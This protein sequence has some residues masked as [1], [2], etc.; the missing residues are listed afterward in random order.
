MPLKFFALLVVL[1]PFTAVH[2]SYLFSAWQG[3]VDWCIPYWHGCT[4]ISAAGRQ[5]VAFFVFKGLMIPAAVLMAGYWWLN[6]RWLHWLGD[7]A[8]GQQRLIVVVG[9][10]ASLGLILYSSVLGAVGDIYRIERRTGVMLYFGLTLLAQLLM[11]RRVM[12]LSKILPALNRP[13][14]CQLAICLAM[15]LLGVGHLLAELLIPATALNPER[16]LDD[17]V[18]WNF[19]LLMDAYYL[20]SYWLW[21]YQ[22]PSLDLQTTNHNR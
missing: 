2:A 13:C 11:L 19:A 16:D 17:I 3:H 1:L 22:H 18:E 6:A 9:F 8:H 14:Q 5:G 15:L 7:T 12:R 21:R 20:C 10:I 4:S